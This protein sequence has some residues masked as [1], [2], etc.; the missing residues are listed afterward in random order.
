VSQLEE[1]P[2]EAANDST[3]AARLTV[4]A[5]WPRDTLTWLTALPRLLYLGAVA[6]A[7]AGFSAFVILLLVTQRPEVAAILGVLTMG[8][9]WY[10]W[11]REL[12]G[13]SK[14]RVQ[15]FSDR[16]V[17]NL[18]VA[19]GKFEIHTIPFIQVGTISLA[20]DGPAIRIQFAL[21]RTGARSALQISLPR[22]TVRDQF[23][24]IQLWI[25]SDSPHHLY[26]ACD[27]DGP[28]YSRTWDLDE[29]FA[30]KRP[31]DGEAVIDSFESSAHIEMAGQSHPVTFDEFRFASV[32][33]PDRDHGS[34]TTLAAICSHRSSGPTV[35][36]M[37]KYGLQIAECA[38]IL[39]SDQLRIRCGWG[40]TIT[41][42]LTGGT[43][44]Y[45]G[46]LV[47]HMGRRGDGA[48]L[49]I[50]KPL[51]IPV[52]LSIFLVL[53]YVPHVIPTSHR[54]V[55]TDQGRTDQ[56]RVESSRLSSS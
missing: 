48:A 51:P 50:D 30:D 11:A 36:V 54:S 6:A 1:E 23:D 41:L 45:D 31:V 16:V 19:K 53:C 32:R 52:V 10:W 13:V 22:L 7:F 55:P 34:T 26:V 18:R 27:D 49:L 4:S 42:H 56:G 25:E 35:R 9:A 39:T 8:V 21:P 47:G 37:A 2:V 44:D 15:F 24:E 40:A 12:F 20:A 14:E 46:D 38:L 33:V 43:F 3:T 17:A 5:G 28:Q 29:V